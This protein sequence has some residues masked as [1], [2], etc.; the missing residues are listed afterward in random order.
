MKQPDL[1]RDLSNYEFD[2][3]A[4][5]FPFS[6]RLAR[7]CGWSHE[8]AQRVID[9]YRRFVYLA[10]VAGHPVTPSDEVDQVWHL[11]LAYTRSYWHDLCR[12]I[13]G[14]E[15]H[16]GPTKGGQSEKQKFE[17]WYSKT[18]HSYSLEFESNPPLDIWPP[19][20]I[21][22]GLAPFYRRFNSKTH[23]LISKSQLLSR[24]RAALLSVLCLTVV[25]GCSFQLSDIPIWVYIVMAVAWI[26]TV[27]VG[28]MSD[29]PMPSFRWKRGANGDGNAMKKDHQNVIHDAGPDS[30]D[31]GDDDSGCGDGA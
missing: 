13:L 26:T 10:V 2:D 4:S 16:H 5:A 24:S 25:T 12:E 17:D 23:W 15:L 30:Y 14:R 3:R 22:F 18:K 21:R 31:G 6:K 27:I 1:W 9:E 20:E 19:P 28:Y 11:H 29:A 7:D 8:F